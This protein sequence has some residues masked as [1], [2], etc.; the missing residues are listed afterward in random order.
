MY[1][2]RLQI[3]NLSARRI[4]LR[5]DLLNRGVPHGYPCVRIGQGVQQSRAECDSQGHVVRER[6]DDD[7]SAEA[8]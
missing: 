5:V 4:Q 2:L 7:V 6:E 3:Q 1:L 8:E